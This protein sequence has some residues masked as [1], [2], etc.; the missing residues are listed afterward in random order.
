MYIFLGIPYSAYFF[1][2]QFNAC[3]GCIEHFYVFIELEFDI[4]SRLLQKRIF[5]GFVKRTRLEMRFERIN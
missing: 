3:N 2:F 5:D 1:V 4:S